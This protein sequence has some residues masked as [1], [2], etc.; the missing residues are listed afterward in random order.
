MIMQKEIIKRYM[1]LNGQ[2]TLKFISKDTQIQI[3]RVFRILNGHEM[4][5]SEYEKFDLSIRKKLC[6]KKTYKNITGLQEIAKLCDKELSPNSLKD[7]EM[8][9]NRKLRIK[10]ISYFVNN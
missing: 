6:E 5:I 3:T 1:E 4:K 10:S 7:I 2:P 9:M 8:F